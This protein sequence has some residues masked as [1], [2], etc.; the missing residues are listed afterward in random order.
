MKTLTGVVSW[1]LL[2]A[3]AAAQAPQGPP[4]PSPE[5]KRLSFYAGSKKCESTAQAS[6]FG[7]G[8]TYTS[9]EHG[10][11]GLGGFFIVGHEEFSGPG[12]NG[13]GVV[14]LG[15]DPLKKVYTFH[16]FNSMGEADHSVG[17]VSGKTWTWTGEHNTGDKQGRMIIT[18]DSSTNYSFKFESST[19]GGKTWT[20]V[21][22]GKCTK[23]SAA[24]AAT[25]K[26]AP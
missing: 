2:T 3:V 20:T 18:E 4:K 23:Q 11:W 14:Y 17:T 8:G 22:E 6:S 9:T 7:P 19:D 5:L 10:A 16:G 26:P 12:G 21:E 25:K 13:K 1:A 15:Y 24:A